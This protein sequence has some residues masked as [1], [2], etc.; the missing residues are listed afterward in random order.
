MTGKNVALIIAA[1]RDC[2]AQSQGY[3]APD[4]VLEDWATKLG[5]PV[6]KLVRLW[7]L[8]CES[9]FEFEPDFITEA[10]RISGLPKADFLK[11]K[12]SEPWLNFREQSTPVAATPTQLEIT[13]MSSNFT[14]S[15][16]T[17][18]IRVLMVLLRSF[19]KDFRLGWAASARLAI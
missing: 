18:P 15:G 16:S 8:S 7:Q 9:F 12:N 19:Q 6:W 1:L 11:A 13:S 17:T 10:V 5:F 14:Q 4:E 3:G 2:S